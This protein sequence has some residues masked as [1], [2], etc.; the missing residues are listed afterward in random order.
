MILFKEKDIN[1]RDLKELE[2]SVVVEFYGKLLKE[3]QLENEQEIL[4]T[5]DNLKRFEF[6]VGKSYENGIPSFCCE[7][8][9]KII[10]VTAIIHYNFFATKKETVYSYGTYVEPNFRKQRIAVNL[11]KYS[12]ERLKS[13]GIECVY[14]KFFT[15]RQSSD[16]VIKEL[17]LESS[18]VLCKYL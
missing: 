15:S 8:S 12:F 14:G 13:L 10:A 7:V 4:L 2:Q 6:I 3:T 9:N 1:Y 5:E 18:M 11:I 17:G 16:K